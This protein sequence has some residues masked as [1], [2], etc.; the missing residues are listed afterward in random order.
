LDW[1][2]CDGGRQYAGRKNG[3]YKLLLIGK[4][5]TGNQIRVAVTRDRDPD[6]GSTT[7]MLGESAVCLLNDI[8]KKDIKGGFWTPATTMGQRLIERLTTKAGLIFKIT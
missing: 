5:F 2:V 1:T 7:K 6:Y 8:G 3:F 4:N